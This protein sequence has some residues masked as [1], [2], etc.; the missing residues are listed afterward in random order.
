MGA[1][2]AK[3]SGEPVA[4]VQSMTLGQTPEPEELA[5]LKLQLRG[6]QKDLAQSSEDLTA[7]IV[8]GE[9]ISAQQRAKDTVVQLKMARMEA[10]V[11]KLE[12]EMTSAAET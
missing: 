12:L 8:R 6:A 10:L 4:T 7:R 1:G 2:W 11:E 9:K 3:T 5:A